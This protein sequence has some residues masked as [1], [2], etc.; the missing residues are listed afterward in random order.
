MTSRT[1]DA[2]EVIFYEGAFSSSMYRIGAGTVG[3]Y[4]AYGTPDE[5]LLATLGPGQYFGEMGLVE[6]YP[7]SATAVALEASTTTDEIV[8]DEFDEALKNDPDEIL[9][10]LRQLSSRLR[11]MNAQ[12]D[13]ARHAIHE[14]FEVERADIRRSSKLKSTL[15]SMVSFFRRSRARG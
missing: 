6:C 13:E 8:Y 7:R 10:V 14:A 4:A 2:G 1:F 12:Y 3:I 5:R 9:V 15:Q 11:E